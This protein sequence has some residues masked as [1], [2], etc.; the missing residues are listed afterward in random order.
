VKALFNVLEAL[1]DIYE[2]SISRRKAEKVFCAAGSDFDCTD[3]SN[4]PETQL[5]EIEERSDNSNK[6][7]SSGHFATSSFHRRVPQNRVQAVKIDL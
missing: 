5:G 2:R 4:N 3:M 7:R 1:C 6:N